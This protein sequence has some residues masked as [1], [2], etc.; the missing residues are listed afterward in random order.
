MKRLTKLAARQVMTEGWSIGESQRTQVS[1]RQ[2]MDEDTLHPSM[3]ISYVLMSCSKGEWLETAYSRMD[4]EDDDVC[5]C[6]RTRGK[7]KQQL[8]CDGEKNM[9]AVPRRNADRSA[10]REITMDDTVLVCVFIPVCWYHFSQNRG[11]QEGSA[12]QAL[13]CRQGFPFQVPPSSQM[14]ACL[15]HPG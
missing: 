13:W 4:R 15:P 12:R 14:R 9:G 10:S 11:S 6:A 3:R 2:L 5:P 7:E 1:L 8:G